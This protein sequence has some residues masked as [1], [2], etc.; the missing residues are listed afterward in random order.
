MSRSILVLRALG[1][2]DLLTAVPALRGLRAAYPAD[3]VV[4]AAPEGLRDLVELIDAVDELLPT[5]GLGALPQLEPPR[6]A[7]NLHGSGPESI[8]DLRAVG[9]DELLTHRHPDFPELP[10]PEWNPDL[11]EVDRWC[12]LLAYSGIDAD[13]AA[14]RL[15]EPPGPPV[16]SNVVV[17]HPGAA[18]PA[19]R[20]PVDRF[21]RV[22]RE[23]TAEGHRV[24]LTGSPAEVPLATAV[25]EQA[26]LPP[27]TVYAGR[28]GLAE[29]AALVAAAALVVC[30]DTGVGH[31]ATAFGT[32]SVLIFGPTP[33]ARWGPPAAAQHRTLWAG[34]VGDPHGDQPDPGLLMVRPEHVLTAASGL[35][36]EKVRHG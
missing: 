30:G 18:Y 3:R 4:L 12:R 36:G 1:L 9:A 15:P 11:H 28:T 23:L 22:A 14:L 21:A 10:G 25:A 26:E 35:L 5:A 13:P 7:V 17:L 27:D 34:R 29:L 8:R 16:E 31:L 32:P 19:R 6:L 24:V 33:P 2:G 20:W